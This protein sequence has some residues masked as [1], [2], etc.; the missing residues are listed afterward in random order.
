MAAANYFS[1]GARASSSIANKS[2]PQPSPHLRFGPYGWDQ[3][4]R[5]A[6]SAIERPAGAVNRWSIRWTSGRLWTASTLPQPTMFLQDS[7]FTAT[8]PR[9][10][11]IPA[12][13]RGD[14][15]AG[16]V[17]DID[18]LVDLEDRASTDLDDLCGRCQPGFRIAPA[19]GSNANSVTMGGA[20]R[21]L[22]NERDGAR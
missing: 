20:Q 11:P 22:Q 8:A 12:A 21:R 4:V 13:A 16:A 18:A 14:R 10:N 1:G 7:G 9:M 3:P 15:V 6:S 5:E 19:N 2:R 17:A